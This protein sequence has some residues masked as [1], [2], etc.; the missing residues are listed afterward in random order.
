VA[1]YTHQPIFGPARKGDV[2]RIVLDPSLARDKL[3]WQAAMP[4]HSGLAKT[5]KFFNDGA[6]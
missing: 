6:R 5:F 2:V 1:G 3:G 4:L